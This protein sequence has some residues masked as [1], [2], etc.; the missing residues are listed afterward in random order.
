MSF[1]EFLEEW[2]SE[3]PFIEAKTSGSTGNPKEIVLDKDFVR[4]SA[5]RTISFFGINKDSHL[6]SCIS[7]DS[8]GG[9]MMAV[10]S[11]LAGC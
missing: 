10:R 6:Y 2:N 8:I 1:E 5:E 4:R 11:Q 9:K 3:K 7:A